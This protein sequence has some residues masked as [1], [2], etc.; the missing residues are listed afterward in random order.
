MSDFRNRC[1]VT[2]VVW[3]A[4]FLTLA[5][6]AVVFDAHESLDALIRAHDDAYELDEIFMASSIGGGLGLAYSLFRVRELANEVR[7]RNNAEARVDWAKFHDCLT[8]LP[9]RQ[10]LNVQFA[11]GV[12][13]ASNRASVAYS[14][15]LAG[16]EKVNDELGQSFGD[17]VIQATAARL[18]QLQPFGSVFHL[19]GDRFVLLGKDDGMVGS[20]AKKIIDTIGQPIPGLSKPIEISANVGYAVIST[21]LENEAAIIRAAECAM[22]VAKK[23]GPNVAAKFAPE[24]AVARRKREQ[25]EADLKAA[26]NT[27]AIIPYYQPLVDLKTGRVVGYEALARWQRASGEFVPPSEFVP[28]AEEIGVIARLTQSLLL[29]A[30][31]D[32]LLWPSDTILAFNVSATQLTDRQL[33]LR[34]IKILDETGLPVQ[35]LELEVTEGAIIQDAESALFVLNNLSSCG[36]RIALDDF[37]TGYSSLSQLAR[38]PLEKIK[39]DRS[40][41]AGSQH[42]EKQ[43]NILKAIISLASSLGMSIVAEGIERETEMRLLRDLGCD[44]GQ[45]FFL[46]RPMASITGPPGVQALIS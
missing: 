21:A 9:N 41:I 25:L 14:I 43:N 30:C 44:I 23:E 37:G 40:F 24:M 7:R 6:C 10:M 12:A 35:R 26:I 17:A 42:S 18:S 13:P 29:R 19:G 2:I 31:R 33:G 20:Q 38:Y 39:I 15:D 28:L 22:Y 16:L 27:D 11:A 36:I 32:A 34:I 8:G 3:A 46:G 1:S 4:A 45:G 5:G